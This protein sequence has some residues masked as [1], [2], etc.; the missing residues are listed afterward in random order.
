LD[1]ALNPLSGQSLASLG[2][3]SLDDGLTIF[4]RHPCAE[5]VLHFTPTIVGLVGSLHLRNSLGVEE[6]K[7]EINIEFMIL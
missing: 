4:S 5:A 3:S 6:C 7:T 2:S 1:N